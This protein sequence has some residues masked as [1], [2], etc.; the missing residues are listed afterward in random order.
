MPRD[1]STPLAQGAT[2][3]ILGGGQLGRM[4]S[5]AASRL[6]F[7][8]HVYDPGPN[9]PAA[10][11]AHLVTTAPYED[12]DALYLS[13]GTH[14]LYRNVIANTHDDGIDTGTPEENTPAGSGLKDG[15]SLHVDEC[16]IETAFHEGIALSGAPKASRLVSVTHSAV[17]NTQQAI[18]VGYSGEGMKAAVSRVSRQPIQVLFPMM[19]RLCQ[20]RRKSS[21]K[22]DWTLH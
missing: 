11:V 1:L 20:R 12:N 4:L 19:L 10:D 6:G 7:R 18:E 17:R 5:V 3:G 21:V 16:V 2:I 15:G 14:R 9:P 22:M 8:T 13:G